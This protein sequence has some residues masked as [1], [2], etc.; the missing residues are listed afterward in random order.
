MFNGSSLQNIDNDMK[1]TIGMPDFLANG[2][3]DFNKII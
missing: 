1:Y 3:N 2:G